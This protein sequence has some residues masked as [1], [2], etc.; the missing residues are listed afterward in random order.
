MVLRPDAVRERLVK[1]EEVIS[2]LKEIEPRAL[3]EDFRHAWAAERGLQLAAEIIFDVGN[4]ILSAHQR[5][6]L[7]RHHRSTRSYPRH[8][9]PDAR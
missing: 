7:R 9:C 2:R 6:G 3:R 1:L 5:G 4:H 8:R